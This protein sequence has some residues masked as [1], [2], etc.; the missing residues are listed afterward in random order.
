MQSRRGVLN[1]GRRQ[2][3]WQQILVFPCIENGGG[4]TRV[5]SLSSLPF[6]SPSAGGGGKGAVYNGIRGQDEGD[7]LKTVLSRRYGYYTQKHRWI[8][9]RVP[10]FGKMRVLASIEFWKMIPL[11]FF[12]RFRHHRTEQETEPT[13]TKTKQNTC[14]CRLELKTDT[15]SFMH[16]L[17]CRN[18]RRYKLS[19][20]LTHPSSSSSSS[21]S[22][23]SHGEF[24]RSAGGLQRRKEAVFSER[25]GRGKREEGG[26]LISHHMQPRNVVSSLSHNIPVKLRPPQFPSSPPLSLSHGGGGGGGVARGVRTRVKL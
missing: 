24:S 26:K 4:D 14:T 16:N 3:N 23:F 12:D 1:A 20:D 6:S 11:N 21:S 5:S 8:V 17:C 15:A 19:H 7:P 10:F 2:S 9:F 13:M 22:S 25:G 18:R